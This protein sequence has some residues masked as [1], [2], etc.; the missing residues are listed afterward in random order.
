MSEPAHGESTRRHIRGS[1]LLLLGRSVALGINFLVNVLTVRMLPREEYGEFAYALAFVA[2]ATNLNLLGLGRGIAQEV[3]SDE[4][5]G[6]IR[7]VVGTVLFC[8]GV[9]LVMGVAIVAFVRLSSAGLAERLELSPS[10]V[11]LL[12][13]AVLLTP[14]QAVDNLAQGLAAALVGARAIFFRRQ[15]LGPLLKLA[16]VLSVMFAE[17]GVRWLAWGYV[18]AGA[19]GALAYVPILSRAFARRGWLAGELWRRPEVPVGSLVSL[20]FPLL[21]TGLVQVGVANMAVFFLELSHGPEEVAGLR[22]V[23]PVA[24]LVL[25]VGE[26]FR[27][28]FVPNASRLA[29]RGDTTGLT[30]LYWRTLLWIGALSFPIFAAVFLLGQTIT[31][32]LFE[33]RY[34]DA[35]QLLMVLAVGYYLAGLLSPCNQVLQVS[36]R[37]RALVF[38]HLAGLVLVIGIHAWL[39]PAY[40]AFG[41]ALATSISVAGLNVLSLLAV[42]WTTEVGSPGRRVGWAFVSVGVVLL[43]VIGLRA[44]AGGG[45]PVWAEA[46]GALA[47]SAAVLAGCWSAMEL[48]SVFPELGRLGRSRRG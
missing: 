34:A 9:V 18:I 12:G 48:G 28:L 20:A 21:C 23:T 2:I 24:A 4:E 27:L 42:R 47:A 35:G 41:A 37:L 40:G 46:A 30:E 44:A 19:V 39:V 22:A 29:A 15:V 38:V 45:V 11:G 25:V 6:R 43:V 14:I 32:T 5:H 17:G 26:S 33:V 3:S 36:R 13:V 1:G 10:A 8:V 16:A 7:R 31:V